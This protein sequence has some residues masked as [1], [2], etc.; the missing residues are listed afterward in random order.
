MKV[1]ILRG[2]SGCGK[3]TW[4]E[5]HVPQDGV[6]VSADHFF[7]QPNGTYAFDAA[8]LHE[9][10]VACFRKFLDAQ[11]QHAST[12]IVDN[13][14]IQLWEFF[15]YFI[16]AHA[17]RYD[18]ELLTFRCDPETAIARK[19]WVDPEKVRR[20][21]SALERAERFFPDA[22]KQAHRIIESV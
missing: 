19:Q 22:V 10:H 7:I 17:R 12:V 18:V 6:I 1:I 20:S 11:E 15:P 13:S 5:E 8:K 2:I 21:A 3:S 9:A 14:N 16:A 4:A